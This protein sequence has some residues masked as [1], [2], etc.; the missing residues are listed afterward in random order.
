MAKMNLQIEN[1]SKAYRLGQIGTGTLVNDL[2]RW[3][4]I[5]TKGEDPFLKVGQENDRTQAGGEIVWALKDIN[6]NVYEGD[7]IGLIGQNGAGKSTLLKL[8]SGVTTPTTG[9]IRI[10]GKMASL[11]EVG[12]GFHPELSGRENVFLNGAI[13]GMTKADIR[14]RFDE[15]VDFAGVA[16]YIDTPV[17]RYSSGMKVR[18]G[19][20]VAA[21][22]EPDILIVDEVLA[23]GDAEFQKKAIGKMQN[24]SSEKGRTVI[25]VSHNMLSVRRL[26]N[27]G[28]VLKKGKMTFNGSVNDAISMYLQSNSGE[29][30]AGEN[31]FIAWNSDQAPGDKSIQ[32]IE[33]S[34]YDIHQQMKADFSSSEI[35]GVR[36]K[37]RFCEPLRNF[38]LIAQLTDEEDN[39][40][41][42][43]TD[44][45][46]S[47]VVSEEGE[48]E[49]RFSL[50]TNLLNE[51]KYY[52][53]F[54]AG[55]P[56]IKQIIQ[57]FRALVFEI[58]FTENSH[59]PSYYKGKWP[60]MIA[61]EI[62]WRKIKMEN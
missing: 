5:R 29:S 21:H 14:K 53:K 31:G 55:I 13:L 59:V 32:L 43:T 18:L 10:K 39:L 52:L 60:G 36:C 30:T 6:L 8:L 37:V 1:V 45:M 3:W 25:F 17:K 27:K 20:A 38:R 12:T 54:S 56:G 58:H 7:I 26:C 42:S 62:E 22:L 51:K 4:S 61:P 33:A 47:D 41:F 50:P 40:I 19:F 9:Q 49:Y 35:I 16:K 57:P 23:V 15:I 34:L 2:K 28:I 44:Q 48:Y 11:L 24:V 46:H